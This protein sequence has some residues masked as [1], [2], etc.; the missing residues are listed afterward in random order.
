MAPFRRRLAASGPYGET[1]RR[2]PASTGPSGETPRRIPARLALSN[3]S[4]WWLAVPLLPILTGVMATGRLGLIVLAAT[5]ALALPVT[6]AR[7]PWAASVA[8][9]PALLIPIDSFAQTHVG[10]VALSSVLGLYSL[11]AVAIAATLRRARVGPSA[12]GVIALMAICGGG[13]IGALRSG[14]QMNSTLT[15]ILAWAAAFGA[16]ACLVDSRRDVERLLWFVAPIA[17]LA[18]V[19]AAIGRNPYLSLLP[20][21]SFS[22]HQA[23]GLHRSFATFGAPLVAGSAFAVCAALGLGGLNRRLWAVVPLIAVACLLTV[24]RSAILAVGV[25]V[26]VVF[27][28]ERRSRP[29]IIVVLAVLGL[30]SAG[31]VSQLPY[32]HESVTNR[33][34]GKGESHSVRSNALEKFSGDLSNNTGGLMLGNGLR[35]TETVLEETGRN[36]GLATLDNQYVT[37]AYDVGLLPMLLSALAGLIALRLA[38]RAR[39]LA[40]LPAVATCAVSFFFFDGMYW[41]ATAALAWFTFGAIVSR[42]PFSTPTRDA[43]NG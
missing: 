41:V 13:L 8:L 19:E 22:A 10:G 21:V 36:E 18:V 29:R 5:L 28:I 26:L 40:F 34:A 3:V 14:H 43:G 20:P 35:Y 12:P 25:G 17:L 33:L 31:A 23:A 11:L 7:T 16:G 1:P 37:F 24:S 9:A 38:P 27:L 6:L 42:R 32:F 2:L 30:L 4:L 39:L 15:L